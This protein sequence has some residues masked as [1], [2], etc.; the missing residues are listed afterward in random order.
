MCINLYH[1]PAAKMAVGQ[2]VEHMCLHP[3]H[4]YYHSIT[5]AQPCDV[6]H[7]FQ[8]QLWPFLYI[9]VGIGQQDGVDI[10]M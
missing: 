7:T 3:M 5:S 1:H 10:G 2:G 9:W 8:P 6:V 4:L